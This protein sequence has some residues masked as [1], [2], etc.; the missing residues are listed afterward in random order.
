MDG[1]CGGIAEEAYVEVLP[2]GFQNC[3]IRLNRFV[4]L[5][6][7]FLSGSLSRV[8]SMDNLLRSPCE[9]LMRRLRLARLDRLRPKAVDVNEAG[10][11]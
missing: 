8:T 7:P 5:T 3:T 6:L 10:L 9:V 4:L 1:G 11:G 2:L